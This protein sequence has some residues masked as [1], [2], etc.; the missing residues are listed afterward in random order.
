MTVEPGLAPGEVEI[1]GTRWQQLQREDDPVPG[2]MIVSREVRIE[3]VPG[4]VQVEARWSIR[5]EQ[6]AW[7]AQRLLATTSA[8]VEHVRWN[9]RKAPVLAGDA[10]VLVVERIT[11][12][13]V[14]ELQAFVPGNPDRGMDLELL[15]APT[16]TVTT[17]GFD[18][19]L[20]VEAGELPV[21]P[22]KGTTRSTGAGALRLAKATEQ[23]VSQRG[24]IVVAKVAVGVT[25]GDA[26]LRG[27][28]HLRWEIRHGSLER[29]SFVAYGLG[30]D[31]TIEG[32]GIGQWK[33]EGDRI[34]VTLAEATERSVDLDLRWTTAAPG[35]AE[36]SLPLPTIVPQDVF[37][38]ASAMQLARDG[39]VDVRP[40]LDSWT[41]VA[42]VQLPE[43]AKGL[44]EGTP[45]AAFSRPR[46]AVD[47]GDTLQLLRLEP[48]P[49]PPMVVD[50]ADLRVATTADG[51]TL[52]RARYEIRNERASHLAVTPPP[53]MRLVG[54]TVGGREVWPARD[55]DQLRIPLKRSLE[56]VQGSVTVPVTVA[57]VAEGDAAWVRRERREVP[58]P[59]IDAPVTVQRVTVH[60]PPRYRSKLAVGKSGVVD[61]FDRGNDVGYGFIDDGRVAQ[62][63]RV[64]SSAI[65]AWNDNE[66]DDALHLLDQ[67]RNIGGYGSNLE[68]LEA[69]INLVRPMLGAT[70]DADGDCAPGGAP[71]LASLVEG[72]DSAAARRVRAQARARS[73]KKQAAYAKTKKRAKAYKNAGDYEKAAEAYREALDTSR[74]LDA[75][76]DEES[77]EYAF[78]AEQLQDELKQLEQQVDVDNDDVADAPDEPASAA[79]YDF[80]DDDID[81]DEIMVERVEAKDAA[82][83]SLAGVQRQ[84]MS[85]SADVISEREVFVTAGARMR[86]SFRWMPRL[87]R[88]IKER[89]DERR[90][91][92]VAD[93]PDTWW[94]GAIMR[95]PQIGEPVRYQQLLLE[96]GEARSVPVDAR[97]TRPF[98][99]W[100][101]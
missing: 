76:Q 52:M 28:G 49:G 18:A 92:Y 6:S 57:F 70:V 97:R 84:E 17:V 99:P 30:E 71:I 58:L 69:N 77:V 51:G 47:R 15:A 7:L 2:P 40:R 14:L 20:T 25:V 59:V 90:R 64:L 98:R 72:P 81:E 89:R 79:V 24:P 9:G 63:D 46:A 1:E 53:G 101:E 22:R 13:G 95:V 94:G 41:P 66:F 34:V 67:F 56:T 91:G 39:E 27:R 100:S 88:H 61:E 96:A 3:R 85:L 50:V 80:E 19:E 45:T 43:W 87:I 26:E 5:S 44:V 11:G 12:D 42:S 73:G 82:G 48:V 86:R 29:V 4:G 60:L 35:G 32:A 65:D 37:R 21:L 16:G 78:E 93:L 8:R 36:A 33:R 83:I 23:P 10:G 74:E 62:A 75:L 68:G 31:L 54:V 55:G 38:S